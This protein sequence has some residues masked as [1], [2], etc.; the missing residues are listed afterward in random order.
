LDPKVVNHRLDLCGNWRT[1]KRRGVRR[2]GGL[3]WRGCRVG[4]ALPA[5]RFVEVAAVIIS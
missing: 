5:L 4:A 1:Q 3:A 2:E